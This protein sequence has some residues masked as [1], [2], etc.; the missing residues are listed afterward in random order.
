MLLY[1][2]QKSTDSSIHCPALISLN[3]Y[4]HFNYGQ[5]TM[6][7]FH[8]LTMGN[9]VSHDGF[10]YFNNGK[11]SLPWMGFHTSTMGNTSLYGDL[12]VLNTI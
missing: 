5:F 9:T 11:Y 7:G 12:I 8:T 6:M 2:E 10:S 1:S 4:H 3:F